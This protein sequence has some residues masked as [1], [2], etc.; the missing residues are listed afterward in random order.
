MKLALIPPGEFDM[1]STPEEVAQALEEGKTTV[2]RSITSRTCQ[3]N[4]HVTM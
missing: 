2:C 1:G 3:R 4:R